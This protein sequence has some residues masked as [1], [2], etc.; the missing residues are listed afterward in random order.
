VGWGGSDRSVLFN[1]NVAI[2]VCGGI[3]SSD[4]FMQ[5]FLSPY[6]DVEGLGGSREQKRL[7]IA[8]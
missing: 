7:W 8:M 6:A 4:I 2:N 3:P 1:Y 5:F